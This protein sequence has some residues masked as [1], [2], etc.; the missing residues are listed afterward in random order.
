MDMKKKLIAILLTMLCSMSL[1]A[2]YIKLNVIN[3]TSNSITYKITTRTN[4]TI[5]GS[6]LWNSSNVKVASLVI[7]P[8][9]LSATAIKTGIGRATISVMANR[10]TFTHVVQAKDSVILNVTTTTRPH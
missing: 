2:Q 7:S 3:T 9:G 8:N 6:P 4:V 10:G 5:T 1:H